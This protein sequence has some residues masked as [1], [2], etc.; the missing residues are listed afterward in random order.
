MGWNALGGEGLVAPLVE[1]IC[2]A[3]RLVLGEM[4]RFRYFRRALRWGS[5]VGLRGEAL[6]QPWNCDLIRLM[7]VG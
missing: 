3:E 5:D 1:E 2:P 4:P 7:A 6:D